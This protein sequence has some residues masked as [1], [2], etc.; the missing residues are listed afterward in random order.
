M[1]DR[2]VHRFLIV[3]TVALAIGVTLSSTQ[4]VRND[5]RPA[6]PP[7]STAQD[8]PPSSATTTG[9]VRD[10]ADLPPPPPGP[11]GRPPNYLHTCGNR[12]YDARGREVR[13]TG[14]N[15]SGMEYSGYAPQ[16]LSHRPWQD[17][18]DQVAALG[19]NTIR[20]PFSSEA[21][22]PGRQISGIDF[23]INPDLQGLTGLEMLDRLVAGARERGL[24]I[25]LD[26]HR[27]TAAQLTTL[28]YSEEVPEGRW[29]ADWRMLAARYYGND[30]V[31]AVDLHN[32]PRGEATW[33]SGDLATDWRLA[34]ERAG[35]AVLAVNP[36]LLVFVEG[37]E[38]YD[39]DHSWWGGDLQGV[40]T[41]PVRLPVPNR[42]VYS[43]HDYGPAVS[44]QA[45]FADSHFPA[46][47]AAI[48]DRRWGYIHRDGIAPVVMGEFG[49]RS[50]GDDRD[51]QWQK[52]LLA[53]LK[54]HE[55]GALV[56]S[57]NPNW[58]TGGIL[59]DDWH[60]VEWARQ[61][62]YQELLA[63]PLDTGARGVFGRAP[64]R[65]TVLF[66]Q[67]GT[68]EPTGTT[69]LSLQLVNDGPDTLNLS[70]FEVRYWLAT[71]AVPAPGQEL[72]VDASDLPPEHVRVDPVSTYHGGQ[73][74][75][76]RVRFDPRA[77]SI[78]PYRRSGKVTIRFRRSDQPDQ[79]PSSNNSQAVSADVQEGFGE[80][81]R[82]DLYVD[83][84]LIRAYQLS[85]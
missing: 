73:D 15:W 4:R 85:S 49:G 27:P 69:V 25:I 44:E 2:S 1:R 76:L 21:I 7:D 54:A 34:A 20:L 3:I 42:V 14:L 6:I 71:N 46:N 66:R 83:G 43:P 50:V 19:Y 26:R 58:D 40:R 75:Y 80:P 39:G 70:H 23:A 22:E 41:A 62:A 51:G 24:K 11:D 38:N 57:L 33:G 36:Y 72:T 81:D 84:Q 79:A 53:Y 65:F 74:H 37:I 35:N 47:L 30:T 60:T 32:E 78:G 10:P 13:I 59:G 68:E 31:I 48:W 63:P 29:L 12:I 64:A 61:G 28:W 52:T 56:W 67:D 17:I 5:A 82:V 77:G 9:C 55:M 45:W 16:G 8:P 18:L